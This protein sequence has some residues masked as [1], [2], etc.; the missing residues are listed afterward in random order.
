MS[1]GATRLQRGYTLVE[2]MIALLVALFLLAGLGS[3]VA[4]TSRTRT[5][6]TSLSELQDEQRL[7]MSLLNDVIQTA[8]YFD[9]NVYSGAALAFPAAVATTGSV[10]NVANVNLVAGQIIGGKHTS[11]SVPDSLAVRFATDGTD[12]FNC[13]GDATAGTYTNFIFVKAGSGS[14][15]TAIPSQLQCAPDANSTNG[16]SL[17]NHVVNMQI[18]YGVSHGAG[19]SNADTYKTADVVT[20]AEWANVVSVR[21]TLTFD[22]PLKGQPG[23]TPYAFFTR[24]IALQARTGSA[25]AA[26]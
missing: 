10:P 24:V 3:M 18:W 21:V 15:P 7:A 25:M 26:I 23:Q 13:R 19:V 17:V 16:V 12:I 8:G 2:I 9:A 11:S 22:N 20:L 14:G 1:P 6:Q 4:G 5:N